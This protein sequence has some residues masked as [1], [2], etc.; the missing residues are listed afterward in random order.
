MRTL[1]SAHVLEQSLNVEGYP[2]VNPEDS[3]GPQVMR[4]PYVWPGTSNRVIVVW[5]ESKQG[6][7]MLTEA[8]D[9]GTAASATR[10]DYAAVE[11]D[12]Q[13]SASTRSSLITLLEE[14]AHAGDHQV[15]AAM[16][17][18]VDWSDR[19]PDELIVAIDLA[20]SLEMAPLAIKLAQLGSCLFPGHE[21]V[22][23]A[24]RVLAPPVVRAVRAPRARGLGASMAWF[25]EHAS[26]YRGQWVA[27]RE[28]KL[29][30][31]AR[32]LE[33][34]TAVIGRG[35]DAVST[36]VTRVL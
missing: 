15:F 24:A 28:G 22:Q 35:E 12:Q 34:L 4:L 17:G 29:L 36:I 31:A 32:S 3:T 7:K 27:V 25:R 9:A 18:A 16:V 19:R 14:S 13:T 5:S 2:D 1:T 8:R 6:A 11:D 23:R 20:L 21:R 30:A 26:R 10:Y 33:E